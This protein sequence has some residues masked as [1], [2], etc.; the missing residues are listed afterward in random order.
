MVMVAITAVFTSLLEIIIPVPDIVL[1]VLCALV[2]ATGWEKKLID[3]LEP[4]EE[5]LTVSW[6]W[7]GSERKLMWGVNLMI[8]I[9]FVV[10]LLA[11][12]LW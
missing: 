5:M 8:G 6:A 9:P 4:D 1:A 3:A 11:G 7:P 10:H 2:L 12:V